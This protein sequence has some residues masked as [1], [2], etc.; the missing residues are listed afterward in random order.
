MKVAVLI[1]GHLRCGLDNFD[2]NLNFYIKDIN[3]DI[4]VHTYDNQD[5]D[6]LVKLYNPVEMVVES[7]NIN[8]LSEEVSDYSKY[9]FNQ[10]GETN[11][12]NT[13][14]MWRKRYEVSKLVNKTYDRVFYTRFDCYSL[15]S[16]KEFLINDGL[17]VPQGGDYRGG[18][19]DL[20]A[21]GSQEIM[22]YYC[23]LYTKVNEYFYSGTRFHPE[24]MLRRHIENK[25]IPITRI[26]MEVMLKGVLFT[27]YR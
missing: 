23:S 24:T 9:M 20:C 16:I 7:D 8:Y 4:Y 13:L 27:H 21:L 11:I 12:F 10:A 17:I 1:S 26:D 18:L 19:L 2:K 5:N 15:K 14:N 25:S 22:N 3:P 6:S